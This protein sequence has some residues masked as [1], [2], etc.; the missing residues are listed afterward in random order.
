MAR[1][2]VGI[3]PASL[4]NLIEGENEPCFA[5]EGLQKIAEPSHIYCIAQQRLESPAADRVRR[6]FWTP[7]KG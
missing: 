2:A 5:P 6:Q 3:G 1:L 7:E 4:A